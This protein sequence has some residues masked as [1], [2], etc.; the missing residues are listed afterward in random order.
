MWS[1]SRPDRVL[2]EAVIA[3]EQ[4]E[5][6]RDQ[7]EYNLSKQGSPR[8]HLV[9]VSA[10]RNVLKHWLAPL[11][12]EAAVVTPRGLKADL[13]AV[14]PHFGLVTMP[15]DEFIHMFRSV[16]KDQPTVL[17]AV[18]T[19]RAPQGSPRSGYQSPRSRFTIQRDQTTDGRI[20]NDVSTPASRRKADDDGAS[21]A[22]DE[23]HGEPK[24]TGFACASLQ[25]G[26]T[27]AT[28]KP[29]SSEAA[30][31]AESAADIGFAS[32]FMKP[33]I[34]FSRETPRSSTV[35]SD[36]MYQG[37]EEEEDY[38]AMEDLDEE[39]EFETNAGDGHEEEK[40]LPPKP[41]SRV[42]AALDYDYEED[43]WSTSR[44]TNRTGSASEVGPP[45]TEDFQDLWP[46]TTAGSAV[47]DDMAAI[48][49]A[50]G[51]VRQPS[52]AAAAASDEDPNMVFDEAEVEML[53]KVRPFARLTEYKLREIRSKSI[54]RQFARYSTIFREGSRCSTLMLV[55]KGR[56]QAHSIRSE[57]TNA[58]ATAHGPGAYFG[59]EAIAFGEMRRDV[60]L[61]VVDECEM[62]VFDSADLKGLHLRI[63]E[64]RASVMK[65]LFAGVT[66][67]HGLTQHQCN[68]LA[69]LLDIVYD[70]GDGHAIF[71]QGDPSDSFYILL[72]GRVGLYAR[73][74]RWSRKHGKYVEGPETLKNEC[75]PE[76]EDPW[77]GDTMFLGSAVPRDR[78]A[79]CLA[80]S[81]LL[82]LKATDLKLFVRHAHLAQS[83]RFDDL[84]ESQRQ[85]RE[86][87][88]ALEGGS[89]F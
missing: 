79:R 34:R 85:A 32:A 40:D 2:Q 35:A 8:N 37:E 1:S 54:I 43:A 61:E 75:Q 83:P 25:G 53:R 52:S 49:A 48:P 33:K 58:E 6:E 44:L 19:P 17:P 50:G 77:F 24:L 89:D 82:I 15:R 42:R 18:T 30:S 71:D 86:R 51:D 10:R 31:V 57:S 12:N 11:V 67:F 76:G 36:P 5:H 56:V 59:L 21:K 39:E 9:S 64:C 66:Y 23:A 55:L 87:I 65:T 72:E 27:Q 16:S 68:A 22:V 81:K 47:L 4:L 78:S 62:L 29:P 88:N 45:A 13:S 73:D 38:E 26:G 14:Q 20:L 28:R 84:I 3:L 74:K 7:K 70:E 80:P 41:P 63:A 60:T 69:P 46:P